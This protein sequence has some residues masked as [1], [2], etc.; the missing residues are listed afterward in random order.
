MSLGLPLYKT[1]GLFQK[2]GIFLSTWD[3]TQHY[4]SQSMDRGRRREEIRV[5]ERCLALGVATVRSHRHWRAM[6]KPEASENPG[7]LKVSMGRR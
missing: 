3:L 6:R 4:G 5:R 7:E 1:E 2:N